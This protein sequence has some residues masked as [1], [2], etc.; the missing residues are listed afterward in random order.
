M[1]LRFH[2]PRGDLK[3][4]SILWLVFGIG[5]SIHYA[6]AGQWSNLWITV[7]VGLLTL[8]I[9][10]RIKVCGQLLFC[11]LI[12]GCLMG[13][14]Y[15]FRGDGINWYRLFRTCLSGYYAYLVYDWV[16]DFD[17]PDGRSA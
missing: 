9:W 4:W 6:L 2:P 10:L 1:A 14:L 3:F 5:G 16:D 7:P 17:R 15:I 11:L 12:L 8:G 13:A